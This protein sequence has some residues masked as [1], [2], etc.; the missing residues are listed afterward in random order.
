MVAASDVKVIEPAADLALL[1][2][3]ASAHFKRALA[4]ATAVVGEVGL[5]GEI[6][7][8]TQLEQRIRE[9][10]RLGY[11]RIIVPDGGKKAARGGTESV[12]KSRIDVVRVR[13][14]GRTIEELG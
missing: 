12:E 10:A 6:R 11:K 2:A 9:A 7:P 1:M 4:A 5:G 13:T 8:V 3:I 14:I